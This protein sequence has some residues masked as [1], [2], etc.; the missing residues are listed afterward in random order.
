MP[1]LLADD[2]KHLSQVLGPRADVQPAVQEATQDHDQREQGLPRLPRGRP[3]I[4]VDRR[5]LVR[6]LDVLGLVLEDAVGCG[7]VVGA[8]GLGQRRTQATARADGRGD[9]VLVAV[10]WLMVLVGQQVLGQQ[11]AANGRADDTVAPQPDCDAIPEHGVL[12]EDARQRPEGHAEGT[13]EQW[14]FGLV[15][16]GGH[17]GQDEAGAD[18]EGGAR[19]LAADATQTQAALGRDAVVLERVAG[20][21]GCGEQLGRAAEGFV[22]PLAVELGRVDELLVALWADRQ[23]NRRK[24]SR[25]G[26]G[27]FGHGP[28]P[29]LTGCCK[30]GSWPFP[31]PRQLYPCSSTVTLPPSPQNPGRSEKKTRSR[32]K[33]FSWENVSRLTESAAPLVLF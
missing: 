6:G 26:V 4:G 8:G 17:V 22:E 9:V 15:G 19:G 27:S 21:K 29:S 23:A 11:H 33:V 24:A 31:Y 16:P 13:Q 32:R 25:P 12:A 14:P 5:G 10:A 1:H 7:Q 3:A 28:P 20:S 18:G 30:G 2:A